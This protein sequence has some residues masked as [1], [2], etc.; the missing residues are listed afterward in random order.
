MKALR[1]PKAFEALTTR[2]ILALHEQL[3]APL[4]RL[5]KRRLTERARSNGWDRS[6]DDLFQVA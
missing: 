3:F 1:D 6:W 5:A 4:D 2:Q